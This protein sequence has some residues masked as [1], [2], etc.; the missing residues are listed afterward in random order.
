MYVCGFKLCV[1]YHIVNKCN[2]S[3]PLSAVGN[4]YSFQFRQK[5]MLM[6]LTKQ[7]KLMLKLMKND[8]EFHTPVS[9]SKIACLVMVLF[10]FL[11]RRTLPPPATL[12]KRR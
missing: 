11:F 10:L 12:G 1:C 5:L 8:A 3:V 6:K 9:S 7:A 4:Q 2:L